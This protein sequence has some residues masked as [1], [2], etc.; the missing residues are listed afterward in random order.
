[1]PRSAYPWSVYRRIPRDPDFE[2]VGTVLAHT[3]GEA[4]KLAARLP[5]APRYP[6]ICHAPTGAGMPADVAIERSA[7]RHSRRR[8]A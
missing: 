8:A 5:D 2:L 7:P 3:E 4:A 1:M 6:V